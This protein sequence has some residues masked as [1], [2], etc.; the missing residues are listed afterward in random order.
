MHF[1]C[2]AID[3]K[4]S[5]EGTLEVQ[6]KSLTIVFDEVHFIVNLYTF[7]L[8]LVLQTNP[9][10]HKVNHL[11]PSQAEQLPK[12]HSLFLLTSLF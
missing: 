12:L 3:L 7:P 11:L 8:P 1:L 4:Q 9:S 10:F 6:G 5:V 2:D